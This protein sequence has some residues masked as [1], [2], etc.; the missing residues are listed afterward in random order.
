M[1]KRVWIVA[2]ACLL[3]AFSAGCQQEKENPAVYG[4]YTGDVVAQDEIPLLPGSGSQG[5]V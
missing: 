2:A 1:R 3:L 4:D 5:G